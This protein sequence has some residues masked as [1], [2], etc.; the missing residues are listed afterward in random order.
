[1]TI[2][3]TT[4]RYKPPPKRKGRKLAEITGP[5]VITVKG[6][7]RRVVLAR[8]AAAEVEEC[9][10]ARLGEAGQTEPSTTSKHRRYSAVTAPGKTLAQAD[11][12]GP[13]KSAIVT[14]P[15]R[16]TVQRQRGQQQMTKL[17]AAEEGSPE[18]KDL[19]DRMMLGRWPGSAPPKKP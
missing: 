13:R 4:Y 17:M 16:K 19:V 11:N 1:M 7:R 2:V 8:D 14:A 12:D 18:T 6:S 15:D 3:T 5:A 10:N 9:V